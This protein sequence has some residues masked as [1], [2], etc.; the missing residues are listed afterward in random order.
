[1]ADTFAQRVM[2]SWRSS[3]RAADQDTNIF[4]IPRVEGD[5]DLV[6]SCRSMLV[7]SGLL[8]S[9]EASFDQNKYIRDAGP[10]C[11]TAQRFLLNKFWQIQLLKLECDTQKARFYLIDQGEFTEWLK[12]FRE[13]VLPVVIQYNLPVS[14]D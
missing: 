8:L 13:G 6:S 12:C 5:I 7:G 3:V 4:D 1:M 10:L 11:P 14:I 9:V 2:S